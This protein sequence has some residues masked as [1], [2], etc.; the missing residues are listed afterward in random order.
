MAVLHLAAVVHMTGQNA[1][2]AGT[3]ICFVLFCL[4]I[5]QEGALFHI[6]IPD[7]AGELTKESGGAGGLNP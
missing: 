3:G 1:R 6:E 2:I 7:G 4:K 5:C